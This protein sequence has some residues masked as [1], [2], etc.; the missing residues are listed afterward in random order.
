MVHAGPRGRSVVAVGFLFVLLQL[1]AV[2]NP[3]LV[4][5]D[6][7]EGYNAAHALALASGHLTDAF[8]LQYRPFCGGC[9][10]DAV[11][12]A[13]LFATVGPRWMAWK[14]VPISFS[15][16]ILLLGLKRLPPAAAWSWALL[17]LLPPPAW[18]SLSLI[19]W[20]NHYEA[21]CLVVAGL[22]LLRAPARPLLAGLSLGAATW[23]GFSGLFALPAATLWLLLHD[24][25]SLARLFLGI[26]LG[27]SPWLL[28]W[29]LAA[30]TPFGEIYG[31]GEAQPALSHLPAQLTTLLHP[32]QLA[33]LLGAPRLS[34]GGLLALPA[35]IAGL[36]L[37][38]RS[39]FG[40]LLLLATASWTGTYLL[41]GFHIPVP[42]PPS[43][44]EPAS[45]RYLAP[46][47]ILCLLVLAEASGRLWS[48]GHRAAT[49]ALL[50]APLLIGLSGR[51]L[52]FTSPFPAPQAATMIA[53][54]L[55]AYRQQ[56]TYLLDRTAHRACSSDDPRERA[57]HGFALGHTQASVAFAGNPTPA[58]ALMGFQSPRG[59][60]ETG[61]YTGAAVALIDHL[62]PDGQAEPPVLAEAVQIAAR[63]GDPAVHE[64]LRTRRY[65]PW[66]S[67]ADGHDEA[68][69]DRLLAVT[70]GAPDSLW[71]LIG[72]R[73]GEDTSRPLVVTTIALPQL[74]PG[75]VS[76]SFAEGL[77][78][79][80]GEQWGPVSPPFPQ[81][82]PTPWIEAFR[83]G[84]ASGVAIRW[85]D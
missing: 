10:L 13:P 76:E 15:L 6:P 51:L 31:Q 81:N 42:E 71:W 17:L 47:L 53:A 77:G 12:A 85:S 83:R 72:L 61:F 49:A 25:R 68:A 45:L 64:L 79:A 7:E 20:G 1:L 78:A 29:Q 70:E 14:L 58:Y 27:L 28:Q 3:A 36:L 82:L 62:D 32:R 11:L 46:L 19:G 50:S 74:D 40:Q 60:D 34:L 75:R 23:V 54:D 73:W 4:E 52:V 57:V 43:L 9:T 38:A 18:L 59:A 67:A 41:S 21:A 69:I 8:T 22:L 44:P 48:T 26:A 2:L 16:L 5:V 63:W 56:A 35:I 37:A 55:R 24:R 80:L 30:T 39:R 66:L 84:Y 33:G 65:A